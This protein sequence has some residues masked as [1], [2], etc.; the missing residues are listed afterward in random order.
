MKKYLRPLLPLLMGLFV[1]FGYGCK[2]EQSPATFNIVPG[3]RIGDFKLGDNLQTLKSFITETD[4]SHFVVGLS[5]GLYIHLLDYTE[6]GI[7]FSLVKNSSTLLDSDIPESIS[8]Y[9]PFEGNTEKGITFESLLT[10]VAEAYGTPDDITEYGDY[11][12]SSLGITFFADDDTGTKVSM[13]S[14]VVPRTKSKSLSSI[15]NEITKDIRM[16]IPSI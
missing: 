8:A 7:M 12:Y 4:P 10:D 16:Q 15:R 2:K 11:D 13:I 3:V 5:G 6:T 1:V 14:I 9:S